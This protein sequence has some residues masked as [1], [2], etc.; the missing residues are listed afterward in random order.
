M[1]FEKRA[2]VPGDVASEK[3]PMMFPAMFLPA[4]QR[5]TDDRNDDS[6]L[7]R[8][9]IFL[10]PATNLSMHLPF[11]LGERIFCSGPWN[12]SRSV[13]VLAIMDRASSPGT[14]GLSGLNPVWLLMTGLKVGLLWLILTAAYLHF[15]VL[16]HPSKR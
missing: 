6:C 14:L 7:S 9:C 4:S 5:P 1:D 13:L 10:A 3:E 11:W 2:G 15:I 12:S 16:Q 8:R